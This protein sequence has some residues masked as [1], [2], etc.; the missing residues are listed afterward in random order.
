MVFSRDELIAHVQELYAEWSSIPLYS[1][2]ADG[3]EISQT[4]NKFEDFIKEAAQ[5]DSFDELI[6]K[7]CE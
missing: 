6:N 7:N 2:E 1:T 5:T 4:A 3:A